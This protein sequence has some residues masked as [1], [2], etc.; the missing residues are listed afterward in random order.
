MSLASE[1]FTG[2]LR[3]EPARNQEPSE[4]I[5]QPEALSGRS[6]G[7]SGPSEEAA[8]GVSGYAHHGMLEAAKWL[9]ENESRNLRA[10][11]TRHRV[12]LS[13]CDVAVSFDFIRWA[14]GEF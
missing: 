3:S 11:L 8:V 2:P 12:R 6:E 10:L 4:S 9:A 14:W 7:P 1:P 13:L 5:G